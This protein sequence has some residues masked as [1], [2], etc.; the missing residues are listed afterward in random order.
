[1][2]G[3]C[4]ALRFWLLAEAFQADDDFGAGIFVGVAHQVHHHLLHL[5]YVEGGDHRLV[6]Q[7][8]LYALPL[9]LDGICELLVDAGEELVDVA[10]REVY[11][12][13]PVL[14]L[15][16]VEQL[17]GDAQQVVHV[18]ADGSDV[19]ETLSLAPPSREGSG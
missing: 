9:H 10:R 11:L 5:V 6:G 2:G 12:H 1:M 7:L 15:L 14:G 16:E 8:Q 13:L 17:V 4:L 18:A 19:L 3:G